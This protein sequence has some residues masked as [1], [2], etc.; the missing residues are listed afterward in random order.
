MIFIIKRMTDIFLS[1]SNTI[2]Y[3]IFAICKNN[4]LKIQVKNVVDN[5]VHN[6]NS[7]IEFCE[8]NNFSYSAVTTAFY[9]NRLYKN[10]FLINKLN[11]IETIKE[12]VEL[13]NEKIEELD[14]KLKELGN[15]Y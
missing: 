4:G 9:R 1:I 5:T 2:A 11:G 12:H 7:I 10:K 15:E 3:I 8:K 6:Y 13:I 14:N